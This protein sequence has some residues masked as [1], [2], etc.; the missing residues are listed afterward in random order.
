[1]KLCVITKNFE[2]S[3]LDRPAAMESSEQSTND[4]GQILCLLQT[5]KGQIESQKYRSGDSAGLQTFVSPPTLPAKKYGFTKLSGQAQ[6]VIGDVYFCDPGQADQSSNLLVFMERMKVF[7][8]KQDRTNENMQRAL[9]LITEINQDLRDKSG[10]SKLASD[11]SKLSGQQL[12]SIIKPVDGEQNF[13]QKLE[14]CLSIARRRQSQIT[15]VKPTAYMPA[16]NRWLNAKES[17][18]LHMTARPLAEDH[19]ID[20][21]VQLVAI[22]RDSGHPTIWSLPVHTED[23]NIRQILCDIVSQLV[24][25]QSDFAIERSSLFNST[26]SQGSVSLDTCIE[27]FHTV[28]AAMN[29]GFIILDLSRRA[30]VADGLG[31]YRSQII[32]SMDSLVNS[33]RVN[34]NVLKVL[35]YTDSI[36]TIDS[37]RPKSSEKCIICPVEAGPTNIALARRSSAQARSLTRQSLLTPILSNE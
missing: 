34:G 16:I 32:A 5:I 26:I 25:V 7:C 37:Q 24:Q 31:N 30:S 23:D 10:T 2:S 18:L 36:T 12:L 3:I 1:M 14:V 21:V 15:F 8:E 19:V 6:A 13:D 20:I 22:L 29:K 11:T 17:M 28:I 27:L 9:H 35:L 33:A 4:I